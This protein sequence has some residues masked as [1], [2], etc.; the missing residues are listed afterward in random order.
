MADVYTFVTADGLIT[1]D[2]GEILEQVATEYQNT[3]GQDLA[4]P[5]S[6]N[7][8]GASTPQGLL[9]VTEALA[10]IAVAN[11]NVAI[12]N[13]INPSIAGG[14]FLDAI[15]ALTGIQRTP[16]TFT[17]TTATITG[18]DGTSVPSGSQ[19]KTSANDLFET[20]QT[21]VIPAGGQLTG[22]VFNAVKSGEIACET[23]AL[24]VAGGGSIVSSVL[25][26]ETILSNT[27]GDLGQATQSDISARSERI[28]T[29]AAQGSSVALAITS[30]VN[31]VENVKSLTFLE[32]FTNATAVF[33]TG[34]PD[35]VSMT[36]HSIY[37]C[38]DGG[39]DLA[40]AEALVSKK[41][42]GASYVNTDGDSQG[43]PVSQEVTVPYSGQVI[44]V[45]FD[46]P[47]E[48]S[49]LVS[50][51]VTVVTPISDPVNTVKN[52]LI[53]YANGDINGIQG[54]NVGQ[55]V[56]AFELAGAVAALHPGI[57]VSEVLIAI[58]PTTP[59]AS[60]E[61]PIEVY[62]VARL[63]ADNIS[64]TVS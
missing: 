23:N 28:A 30:G 26:W 33:P 27:D 40:V 48:I 39:T 19:A 29:L 7:I 17:T 36:A 18:V 22:V 59:I 16:A 35:G 47:A 20:T 41:S 49:I 43:V 34:N 2:A 1:T 63:T 14:I 24:T 53:T 54:L 10:R 6:L 50:I 4:V 51:T 9:I 3:F 64:V 13:Q 61:I 32:N 15:L 57:F 11:N 31:L 5:D 25:G 21:Q 37:V 12:A 44:D 58:S 46:R 56:S 45:L 42:A 55:N 8:Q 52:A 60:T 38:V 62:Q